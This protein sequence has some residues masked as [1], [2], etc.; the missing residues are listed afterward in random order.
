MK[1]W[2]SLPEFI[3]KPEVKEYYDILQKHRLELVIKRIF[4]FIAASGM[5]IIFSPLMIMIAI[6]IHADSPGDIFYRQERITTY[7]RK[8]KKMGR[9]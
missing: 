5:L 1:K 7:G 2:D 3:K 8:Q 4:D 6:L 9:H